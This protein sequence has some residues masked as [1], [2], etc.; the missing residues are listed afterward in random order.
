[1]ANNDLDK[2]LSGSGLNQVWEKVFSLIKILTGDVDVNTKGTLQKQIDDIRV[3]A[4]GGNQA[5]IFET[6]DDMESWL[7]D[8]TNAGILNIGDNLYIVEK[9]VPDWWISEVLTEADSSTGYFYTI[10]TLEG[11]KIDL[12]TYDNAISSLNTNI[13]NLSKQMES[14]ENTKSEIVSSGLGKAL[15]LTD[16][17]DWAAVIAAI[18]G[19]VNRGQLNWSGSNTTKN[20]DSGWYSGGTLDSRPSFNSGRTQGQ[21]DVKNS[22]NSYGL[23]SKAQYD[24]NYNSGV[25]AGKNSIKVKSGTVNCSTKETVN[26]ADNTT[27]KCTA[28]IVNNIGITPIAMIAKDP[29][30]AFYAKISL[31]G[32]GV[33]F[34]EANKIV[35]SSHAWSSTSIHLP[36][37]TTRTGNYQYWILGY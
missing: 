16:S 32:I 9:D 25:T 33:T 35:T 21:T 1:M 26:C 27:K 28:V 10:Q 4:S 23:Y 7:K 30:G 8:E 13:T 17:S 6:T 3:V 20:V 37:W 18:I 15:Q 14:F 36:T 19:V 5:K 34:V 11:P 31:N 2:F 22:P 24:A 12:S 29:A